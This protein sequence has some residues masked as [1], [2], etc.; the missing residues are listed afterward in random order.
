MI[1]LKQIYLGENITIRRQ[2][3]HLILIEKPSIFVSSFAIHIWGGH[4]VLANR[5]LH[6]TH[7][8]ENIPNISPV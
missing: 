2:A 6:F 5:A 1:F 8:A 7:G 4:D 3:R